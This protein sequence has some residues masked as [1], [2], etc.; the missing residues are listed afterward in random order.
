MK[1]EHTG[2]LHFKEAYFERI[3]GGQKLRAVYGKGIPADKPIGEAWLISDH[4]V[5]ESVVDEGPL[6]GKSLRELLEADAGAVLGARAT[7]TVHG[8]FPLLLKLLDAKDVLSV[9]VHPDDSRAEQLG[10]PDVGKTEMW[11]VLQADEGSELVCGL[12]PDVTPEHFK[13]ALA[14]GSLKNLLT[15]IPVRPGTS[16]FV[17]AGT[18]HALGAGILLAE[19]QQN[20]DLTYRIYDWDRVQD[21]GKPRPLH[22]DKALKA[23][24][25]GSAYRGE[26]RTLEY[27]DAGTRR[28]VLGACK[29][30]AAELVLVAGAFQRKT[31]GESFHIILAKTGTVDVQAGTSQRSLRPGEA[32]MVPGDQDHFVATGN[33]EFLDYYVPDLARDIVIPLREAGYPPEEIVR[34]GGD[35]EKSD[36]QTWCPWGFCGRSS[37]FVH[38][39]TS[40][41]SGLYNMFAARSHSKRRGRRVPFRNDPCRSRGL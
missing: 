17:L 33:A 37:R 31:R 32:L 34:L 9:Q 12:D 41:L 3:W 15:R 7:L 5:H 8:R 19:I 2:L 14:D 21:H 10:E 18:V 26:A 28:V 38:I 29:Y 22:I 1:L 24:H 16:V 39:I 25:F 11:H 23:I 20:S 27:T 35:P 4:T 40:C 13:Q 30:F 6:E 36:L